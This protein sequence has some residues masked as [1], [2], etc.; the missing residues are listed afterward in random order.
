MATKKLGRYEILSELGQGA[1][2]VVYKAID[3]L[4]E[5]TVAIKTISLD[6]STEELAK[7]E[8]R[9]YRE[10]KSAGRL[11]HPN[12]VTIYDVGKTDN[13]AYM[14]M[15]FL[16]GRLLKDVLDAHTP[17]RI[18]EIVDIGAK[19][20]GGLAYA[21]EHGIVH[22]D[23]KPANIMLVRGNSVKIMDF[24]IAQMPNGARTLAG[25]AWG[26]PKYMAP[27]QVVGNKVDNRSDIF[28]LGVILYE[29]LTGESPFDG[30]NI[31][32]ILYRIVHEMPVPPRSLAPR[33][34][35]VFNGIIA[36]ALA[37]QP[38]QRYQDAQEFASALR[39]YNSVP[40]SYPVAAAVTESPV[41]K[42]VEAS[43]SGIGD[44]TLSLDPEIVDIFSG[45]PVD[46]LRADVRYPYAT[47]SALN[48]N[49]LALL[50]LIAFGIIM[51][52][53][54][55]GKNTLPAFR[56]DFLT[57]SGRAIQA[58]FS[59]RM[60]VI[61]VRHAVTTPVTTPVAPVQTA[62][63][64]PAENNIWSNA[65]V[66]QA[67]HAKTRTAILNFAV[68][69]WGEIF[70]DG[71]FAGITPPIKRLKIPAGEHKIEISNLNFP[72]YSKIVVLKPGSHRYIRHTFQ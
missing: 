35:E 46:T 2:G 10:A 4:I 49:R 16:E 52:F 25:T 28:A 51:V 58:F 5:R 61:S 11:N 7:F 17:L 6:L 64:L 47:T 20:A 67:E 68:F 57:K 23:V 8:E 44:T 65:G 37:K 34:P 42:T 22:R 54:L 29:M 48:K 66:P 38:D 50:A 72:R 60:P 41:P 39:N 30:D 70:I 27:E 21:H 43:W 14:A 13:V 32:T 55:Y 9:F 71:K 26:S 15:E 45:N 1:M 62:V 40:F 12:I 59:E 69:P 3:P 63:T 53:I 33:V 24:G 56:P 31:N 36:K 18:D 19:I